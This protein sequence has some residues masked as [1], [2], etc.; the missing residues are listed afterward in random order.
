MPHF[1]Q[2]NT[3]PSLETLQAKRTK[4]FN[5]IQTGE[6]TL[7]DLSKVDLEILNEL[8]KSTEPNSE[9]IH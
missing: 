7:E 5:E 1:E 9:E 4:V 2:G 3:Q 8:E 6:A